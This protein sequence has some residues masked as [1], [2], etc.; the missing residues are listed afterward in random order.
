MRALLWIVAIPVAVVLLALVV[1]PVALDKDA[2]VALAAEQIEARSGARLSVAGDASLSLFPEVALAMTEVRAVLPDE[3]G[4]VEAR[5]L[6]TG[7]AL[8]PLFSGRVEIAA[9]RLEGVTVTTLAE[10]PAVARAA[11]MDTSSLSRE[12]LDAFYAMRRELRATQAAQ[13]AAGGLALTLSLEVGE[14][15]LR[16]IRA[17]TVDDQGALISEVLL[18]EL[19]ARDINTAGRPIPMAAE[20]TLPDA[21]APLEIA[22]DLQM[23]TELDAGTIHIDEFTARV[24]GATQARLDV[25]AS[26]GIFLD[27]QSADVTIALR[28]EGLVGEGTLRYAS[29]ESPQIDA[30]LTLS[31]LTPALLVLAGPEAAASEPA[32][33]GAG[34]GRLPLHALRM[35]DTRAK[36]SIARVTVGAHTLEDV[37][38]TLRIVDGVATLDPVSA[39]LHDGA[40]AFQAVFDGHYNTAELST[41]GSIT[42]FDVGRAVTAADAG[43][44]ASGRAQLDWTLEGRGASSDELLGSLTG[45]IHFDT[46]DITVADIGFEGMLCSAV[47]LVNQEEL[48][49]EFPTDTHFDALAAD[50]RLDAG[51]ARLDPLTAGLPSVSL[52]GVGDLDIRSGDL[53]A[54]LRARLSDG[55]RELDPACRINERYT[56]LRWPVECE[57]NLD[58]DPADWCAIDVTE[59]VRDLAEGELKRKA[60]QEMGRLLKKLVRD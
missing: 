38:A 10:D 1:I 25:A 5:S 27:S 58:G 12:E 43:I 53:Q 49:A 7:V 39:R 2:L 51:V 52:S 57:G 9:L 23:R 45:P 42:D 54:S 6:A 24:E 16:D 28:S 22:L 34:D 37:D 50:L 47:A 15:A 44:T 32:A 35:V 19:I 60:S 20:I 41:G 40:I 48:T 11:A 4:V 33:E 13:V 21:D 29:F 59:I 3:A 55:L 36:L 14:L 56:A 26:G 46:A 30:T 8:L 17:V 18:K 31:E